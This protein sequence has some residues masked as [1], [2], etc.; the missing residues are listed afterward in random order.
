MINIDMT[1]T[2]QLESIIAIKDELLPLCVDHN[3]EVNFW[4]ETPLDIDWAR[5]ENSERAGIYK[6]ITCRLD[7]WLIGYIGYWV[8]S[9]SRH[10]SMNMAR[11]DWYYIQ[12]EY[13][14]RGWGRELFKQAEQYLKSIS[15]DRIVIS[16]KLAHDHSRTLTRLGYIEYERHFTKK[17]ES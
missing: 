2:Y 14:G 11:E 6:L 7:G 5:Y 15:V 10:L 12:P 3:R 16:T 9:H 8:G 1:P 17:L 13:R 4:P